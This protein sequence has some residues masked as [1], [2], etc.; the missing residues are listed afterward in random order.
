MGNTAKISIDVFQPE[1]GKERLPFECPRL[2]NW[3]Y[4]YRSYGDVVASRCHV[5][6]FQKRTL[7]INAEKAFFRSGLSRSLGAT[8]SLPNSVGHHQSFLRCLTVEL[9]MF[10]D[11]AVSG[12]PGMF[13]FK[14]SYRKRPIRMRIGDTVS[15]ALSIG[16]FEG[17]RCRALVGTSLGRARVQ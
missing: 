15:T 2:W 7:V 10:C 12:Y 11:V 4:K 6:S 5:D 14:D 1:T 17:R 13:M 16:P 8:A 9:G 3:P